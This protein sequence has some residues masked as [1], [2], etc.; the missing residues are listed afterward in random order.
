M[1]TQDGTT[2]MLTTDGNLT[3]STDVLH[4]PDHCL[5][6]SQRIRVPMLASPARLERA[7]RSLGNGAGVSAG[8]HSC[9]LGLPDAFRD[10]TI[11][12]CYP[13]LYARL[14]VNWLSAL[15]G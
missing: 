10:S 12:H 9:V 15:T 11:L 1:F 14:A 3:P 7:T 8:V 4:Q 13:L 5:D 2:N 6:L